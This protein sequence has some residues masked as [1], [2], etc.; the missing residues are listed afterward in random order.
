MDNA[1]GFLTAAGFTMQREDMN[2][3]WRNVVDAAEQYQ[4]ACENQLGDRTITLRRNRLFAAV[5]AVQNLRPTL[6]A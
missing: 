1:V 5:R 4:E 2:M 3:A 6:R